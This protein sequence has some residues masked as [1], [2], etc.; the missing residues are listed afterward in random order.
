M[1]QYSKEDIFIVTGASSGIGYSVAQKFN[2]LGAS[3]VAIARS[4]DKLTQMKN[5]SKYPENIFIESKDLGKNI[6]ELP[7]FVKSLKEKYGK[8]KGLIYCAGLDYLKV[9]QILDVKTSKDVFDINF[10]APVFMA[11]GFADRRNHAPNASIIFIASVAG[12][13]PDKGQTIY[14][15]SKA[16]L[17]A[18]MKCI[19]K[20]LA[21]K[22]V[23]VNSISPAYVETPMYLNNFENI[24][25]NIDEYPLGIGKP[26]DISN[27]AAFLASED[28]RWITG[29]NYIMD[30][31][32]F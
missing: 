25:T 3:V 30:G 12:V 13:Y 15:G 1:T 7:N 26:A 18:A 8:L 19:S 28:A 17:I 29:Q 10:F 23:R 20:E 6:D 24:G 5:S 16:A 21:T 2:E 22:G 14:G 11:K 9:M 27:M 4:V 32:I 31:G